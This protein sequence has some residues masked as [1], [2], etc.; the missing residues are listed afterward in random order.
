MLKLIKTAKRKHFS[1]KINENATNPKALFTV[2]DHLLHRKKELSLPNHQHPSELA[3]SFSV[4]FQS[5]I[6]R[7]RNGLAT[8][9]V[10]QLPPVAARPLNSHLTEFT[11]VT[12]AD[13]L[14]PIHK[15]AS[16]LCGLDPIPTSLL[17]EHAATLA[18]TIANIVNLSLLTG[19]VPAEL[20]QAIFTPLLKK[21]SLDP[22]ILKNLQTS[23]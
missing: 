4:F 2:F 16:K 11:P 21:S 6:A 18:P 20:K 5:K 15:S 10:S 14:Q 12:S 22:N 1:A 3:E 8:Q 17:K 13:E 23:L 19:E 9:T 7:I